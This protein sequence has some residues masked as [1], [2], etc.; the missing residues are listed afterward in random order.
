MDSRKIVFKE[1]AI[2]AAGELI[3]SA[4]MVGVFIAVG[5]FEMN[6]L[7][8]ALAGC[9]IMIINYFF[10]AMIASLAADQAKKGQTQQA[11]KM[12][13]LSSITRLVLMGLALFIGIKLNANVIALVVPLLFVRPTLLVAEFFRKKGD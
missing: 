3:C 9:C 4:V 2:V 11:K 5:H 13:Q 1:T 6:V 10:M 8:G 12:I 7:W